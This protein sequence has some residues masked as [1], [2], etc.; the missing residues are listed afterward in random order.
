MRALITIN[1]YVVST[2]TMYEC[3]ETL[4]IGKYFSSVDNIFVTCWHNYRMRTLQSNQ[5]ICNIVNAANIQVF[6]GNDPLN[7]I[8][9]CH[10]SF[11]TLGLYHSQE[12]GHK[13]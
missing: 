7:I 5:I 6:D 3:M 12:P 13:L 11:K 9:I 1:M 8:L 10:L 2:C 4:G